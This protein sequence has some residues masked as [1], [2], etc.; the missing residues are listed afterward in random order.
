MASGA[1]DDVS[2]KVV[3]ALLVLATLPFVSVDVDTS[4]FADGGPDA[5]SPA[6]SPSRVPSESP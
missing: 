4:R 3:K 6:G 1:V 5:R 2:E